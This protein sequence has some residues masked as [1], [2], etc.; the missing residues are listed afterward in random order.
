MSF[1][2]KA[3]TFKVYQIVSPKSPNAKVEVRFDIPLKGD[4]SMLKAYFINSMEKRFNNFFH[5]NMIGTRY[6]PKMVSLSIGNPTIDISYAPCEVKKDDTE[7]IVSPG[8]PSMIHFKFDCKPHKL[9]HCLAFMLLLFNAPVS[10]SDVSRP[11]Y[12]SISADRDMIDNAAYKGYQLWKDISVTT[13]S[14]KP[15]EITDKMQKAFTKLMDN[16]YVDI[17]ETKAKVD[18]STGGECDNVYSTKCKDPVGRLALAIITNKAIT[19]NGDDVSFRLN[20][21]ELKRVRDVLKNENA[22]IKI[23]NMIDKSQSIQMVAFNNF[24]PVDKIKDLKECS[25]TDLAKV[26]K[27]ITVE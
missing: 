6:N 3:G 20:P 8:K 18:T 14:K 21:G 11:M 1:P 2:C 12:K 19:I 22:A 23:C 15:F 25:A 27:D 26:L 7:P 5:S 9:G 24:Y 16:K 13:C 10:G 4:T 17:S